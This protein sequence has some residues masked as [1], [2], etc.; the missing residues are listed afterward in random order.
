VAEIADILQADKPEGSS[1]I[2]LFIPSR[3]RGD[4]E[5]DQEYWVHEGLRVVGQAFRGGT[6]FPPGRGVWRDDERGG[7]LLFE[8]TVMILSF[9]NPADLTN[10]AVHSLK[11]FLFRLGREGKQGEVGV[12]IDGAYYGFMRL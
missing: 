6:A 7:D 3:D 9:V 5:V 11:A 1:Q 8:T 10:A 2:V 12:V 4:Q